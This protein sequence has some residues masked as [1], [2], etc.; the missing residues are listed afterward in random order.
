[1]ERVEIGREKGKIWYTFPLEE[2]TGFYPMSPRE[3]DIKTRHMDE[4]DFTSCFA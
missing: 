3:Y 1:V 2:L 4:L